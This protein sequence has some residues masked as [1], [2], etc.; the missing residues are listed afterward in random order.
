M[1]RSTIIFSAIV[2][3]L[4]GCAALNV[5]ADTWSLP[6]KEKYYS[7]NKKYYLEV[8][9]K[10]LEG[11]LQYF[12][13]K[14]DGKENAGADKR[15]K[16][17]RAK[18]TFYARSEE[19]GYLRRWQVALVNEVAPVDVIVSNKGDYVATFDNWHSMGYGDDVVVIYNSLGG[20]VKKFALADL[21]TEGDIDTFKQ[22]A[23]SLW[24]GGKHYIDEAKG[25]LV[26]K[27]VSNGADTWDDKATFHELKIE[28]ATGRPLEP[29]RDLFPQPQIIKSVEAIQ[30]PPIHAT[31]A[32]DK[33]RCT[34]TEASF[35][36]TEAVRFPPEQMLAQAKARPVPPYPAIAQAARAAGTV[37]VEVL[38]SQAGEVL[39]ARSISGHPLLRQAAVAAAL[40][41]KFEFFKAS[42]NPAI[43][44]GV[45]AF[46]FKLDVKDMNPNHQPRD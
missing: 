38:I 43:A 18:G 40:N 39:C 4:V 41:W 36:S 21:L 24:W 22:S 26:L 12:S 33:P 37:V 13:D 19:G 8:T 17:N 16:D 1:N 14:V 27:I 5:R 31:T 34:S 23:S 6:K 15:V 9:P 29:K 32:T 45:V 7:P 42:G 10:K 30:S 11:Q 25:L 35:D 20:L 46:E 3:L 2:S 28:L 44:S